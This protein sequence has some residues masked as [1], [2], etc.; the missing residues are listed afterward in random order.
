MFHWEPY[1]LVEVGPEASRI[2]FVVE[3]REEREERDW[4]GRRR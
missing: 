1:G 4:P 2:D 3:G